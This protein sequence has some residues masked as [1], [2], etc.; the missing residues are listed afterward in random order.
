MIHSVLIF[1]PNTAFFATIIYAIFFHPNVTAL[2]VPKQIFAG[3]LPW[4][5]ETGQASQ[6]C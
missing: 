1:S 2:F 5:E 6:L 3:V 4:W